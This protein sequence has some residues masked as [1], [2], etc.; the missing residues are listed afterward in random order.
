M[1]TRKFATGL[2]L[3]AADVQD[4]II[5]QN[6]NVSESDGKFGPKLN[7]SGSW[8]AIASACPAQMSASCTGPMARTRISGWTKTSG[9]PSRTTLITTASPAK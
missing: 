5:K 7:N 8:T 9:L 1:D 4:G 6:I 2:Y 3:K